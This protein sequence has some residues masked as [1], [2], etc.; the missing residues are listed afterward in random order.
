MLIKISPKE[1]TKQTLQNVG[2]QLLVMPKTC[3][4]RNLIN[5]DIYYRADDEAETSCYT[6][7]RVEKY[8]SLRMAS[9]LLALPR[10]LLLLMLVGHPLTTKHH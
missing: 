3:E 9:T 2:L 8:L 1:K 5:D 6:I 10:M 7:C 4:G